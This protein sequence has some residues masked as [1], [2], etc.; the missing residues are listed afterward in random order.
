MAINVEGKNIKTIKFNNKN[1]LKI[2]SGDKLVWPINN[3]EIYPDIT[4]TV[5]YRNNTNTDIYLEYVEYYAESGGN[6]T[7]VSFPTNYMELVE[8]NNTKTDSKN[9]NLKYI[10][11][12]EATSDYTTWSS[13]MTFSSYN[14]FYLNEDASY[15]LEWGGS[16]MITLYAQDGTKAIFKGEHK[17]G[18]PTDNYWDL[19][20]IENSITKPELIN[21]IEC[22]FHVTDVRLPF[23]ISIS[24]ENVAT[25]NEVSAYSLYGLLTISSFP[26]YFE[27]DANGSN[28]YISYITGE[29]PSGYGT[30][31]IQLYCDGQLIDERDA[32]ISEDGHWECGGFDSGNIPSDAS[33]ISIDCTAYTYR[34]K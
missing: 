13:N 14:G 12:P 31:T 9:I 5:T 24:A 11:D 15:Y 7:I 4:T 32:E 22:D 26:Y 6:Y 28:T 20:Q 8:Y 30:V 18:D 33:G 19:P 25:I 16:C 1:I 29:V 10:F 17:I 23:Y 21:K 27:Y 34:K 3:Y 2:F